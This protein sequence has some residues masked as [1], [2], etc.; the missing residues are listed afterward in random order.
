MTKRQ[1]KVTGCLL[2]SSFAAAIGS[3]Q[4]GYNIGVIN[5]PQRIVEGFYNETWIGR[6]NE[7]INQETLLSLWALSVAIFPVG[8]M[9]GSFGV[10]ALATRL[11]RNGMWVNNLLAFLAAILMGF[12]KIAS[13]IEMLIV[14]RFIIGLHCGLV[15]GLVPMYLGEISPISLRGAIGSIHQLSIVVGILIAQILGLERLMG[16]EKM[17]P[18]LCGFTAFPSLLQVFLLYFSVH[19]PRFLLIN[20]S[21]KNEANKVLLQLRGVV[22][23]ETELKE[24]LE[25]QRAMQQEE[26]VSIPRLICMPSMRQALIISLLVHASQQLSG[27]NA[28]FYYSTAIFLKAGIQEPVY[29]TI[30]VGL[31][32]V[33]FVVIS[34]FLVER[35]GRKTLLFIGVAGMC[36]C[37]TIMAI[38]LKLVEHINWMGYV[39]MVAIFG[40]VAL[41]EIGPG[42]I[43][44]FLAAE[45]FN[46]SA[47]PSAL[48]LAGFSNWT[49]NFLVGMCFPTV[50]EH[51]GPYVFFIFSGLLLFFC[52][53]TYHKVP[54]TKGKSFEE[55]SAGFLLKRI[56]GTQL[57][58]SN[59]VQ[60]LQSDSQV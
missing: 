44:W 42:P 19:S 57:E 9:L 32:N 52:F 21:K 23:V 13:S 16:S 40:F 54:E 45:L 53:F 36:L 6:Y 22:D 33:A 4:Y 10:E 31:I 20:L 7:P 30:G 51:L 39:S 12:T 50:E 14:G 48:A 55:I 29:A 28:V 43:P 18:L 24:M 17:W 46:Q 8:G 15:T 27:I 11:G 26:H 2:L 5:A 59:E 37:S 41:F 56:P 38:S 47:R 1:D 60:A 35:T 49:F 3:F 58:V 34:L 25:E